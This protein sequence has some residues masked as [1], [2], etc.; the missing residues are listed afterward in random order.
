MK[1]ELSFPKQAH[2]AATVEYNISQLP[3]TMQRIRSEWISITNGELKDLDSTDVAGIVTIVP[4]LTRLVRLGEF[5]DIKVQYNLE[6]L[7]MSEVP[8]WVIFLEF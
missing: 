6:R 7:K 8:S 1:A 2:A 3:K 4:F 5:L